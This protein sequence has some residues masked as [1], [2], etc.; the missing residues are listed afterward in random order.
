MSRK[1]RITVETE[2]ILIVRWR[3]G[4]VRAWCA[5]CIARVDFAPLGAVCALTTYDA[6]TVRHL[7]E[8]GKLHAIAIPDERPLICLRSVWGLSVA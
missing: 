4:L 3:R 1:I 7:L 8:T 5:G 2:R 6:A